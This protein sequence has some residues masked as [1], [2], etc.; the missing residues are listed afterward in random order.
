MRYNA[1]MASPL[2]FLLYAAPLVAV[3]LL[4]NMVY[5]HFTQKDR[6]I[7]EQRQVITKLEKNLDRAWAEEMVADLRVDDVGPDAAGKPRMKLTFIQYQP[8]REDAE[9]FR[10]QMTLP[11]EEVY[12]DAFV[13][14]FERKLV[15]EGDGLQGK[16][17]LLFRRAFGDQQQPVDG[18]PLFRGEGTSPIPQIVQVENQPTAFE[19][20]IW[21]RFWEYA[22][23]K[24]LAA[25]KGIRIAQG[26]APHVKVEKN[27]VYKLTLR[28]SG[29]LQITPRLPSAAI[30]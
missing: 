26:E 19:Q 7:A 28:Q 23:D 20:D 2:R 30:R 29:G 5:Q 12:I 15:D 16:S 9:A 14:Q 3:G 24:K 4:G 17:M 10:R 1:A 21:T 8:G 11:G 13:V 27:Q 22:N 6:V 25:E 18:V